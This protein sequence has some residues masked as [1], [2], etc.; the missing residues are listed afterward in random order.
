MF[1]DVSKITGKNIG[2]RTAGIGA[3]QVWTEVG[4]TV[5]ISEAF[6]SSAYTSTLK[7]EALCSSETLVNI[8]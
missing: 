6:Q 1:T 5:E 4:R 7:K 3:L 8:S 2:R